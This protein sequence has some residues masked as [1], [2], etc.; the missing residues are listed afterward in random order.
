M[1]MLT[2][3][4]FRK[5]DPLTLEV[6]HNAISLQELVVGPSPSDLPDGQT[7]DL[8][9]QVH[10]PVNPLA[11]LEKAKHQAMNATSGPLGSNLS[12][13][14]DRQSSL[15]NKLK[16]Q[17]DGAGS[18]LFT[19]TWS[20][21]ATPLGRPYY[22]LV[23]SGRPQTEQ[24][25]S[26]WQSPRARGDAGGQRWQRGDLRNLEDQARAFGLL[27]GLTVSEV[28][29][30]SLSP[31]FCFRLM[32]YPTEWLSCAPQGTPSSRKSRRSSSRQQC[33]VKE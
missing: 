8:F 2:D 10:A 15:A 4:I 7:I 14:A 25:C 30:L 12:E 9:G 6:I 23:A 1:E 17:L 29:A 11:Q 21:K 19:L 27:R 18:I 13:L 22:Q 28:K 16:R 32:G 33:E 26:S 31:K 3:E 20:K 24:G 5:S